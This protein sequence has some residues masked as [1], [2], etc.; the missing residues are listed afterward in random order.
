MKIDIW[1]KGEKIA[2]ATMT[3]YPNEGIY[4]GN[5]FNEA[6]RVIGDWSGTDSV[7]IEKRFAEILSRQTD[8]KAV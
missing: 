7:Q 2:K 1:Y 3:F 8:R 5:L 4:R 6:G